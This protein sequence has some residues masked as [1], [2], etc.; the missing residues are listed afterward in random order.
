LDLASVLHSEEC[1]FALLSETWLRPGQN[2]SLPHFNIVRSDRFD[3]YGGVA[4]AA[5]QSIHIKTLPIDNLL[6]NNLLCQ[7]IDLVGIEA[8]INSNNSLFLWSLYIP[9]SSNPSTTLLNNIFQLIGTNSILGGDVNGH[10]PTWDN[11]NS[12]NHRGDI[13]HTSFS[14]LNLYCLNTGAATRVNRPPF[15]NTAVD[16]T[17]TTNSLYWSLSWHPLEE[18]HGSDHFPL[19]IEHLDSSSLTQAFSDHGASPPR[20]NFSKADWSLFSSHLD[21]LINSFVF[22]NFPLV[23]YDNFVHILNTAA[24]IAILTKR[25]SSKYPTTSPFW[26]NSACSEAIKQ[27]S[28]AFKK[29]I[30]S[31]SLRDFLS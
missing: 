29:Y 12:L 27:R 20:L 28:A 25:I 21:S 15:D 3:G 31:G 14:N 22:S 6:K 10:H 7:S 30:I 16:I 18:P 23:N 9:P 17:I 2:Y 1:S 24:N 19:I 5:Y 13:I 8:F 26:W 4:I 11:N